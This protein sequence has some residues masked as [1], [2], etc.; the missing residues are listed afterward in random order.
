MFTLEE[1]RER[2]SDYCEGRMLFDEFEEWYRSN[3]WGHYDR[4]DDVLSG[5][6]AAV[7]AAFSDYEVDGITEEHFQRELVASVPA[8][9]LTAPGPTEVYSGF[10][11][12]SGNNSHQ[13]HRPSP[14]K[15][16]SNSSYGFS[17]A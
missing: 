15:A 3:S 2:V 5:A 7:E 14:Q 12:E 11:V 10:R 9:V 4:F 16:G 1:L 6:I 8:A 17:H 13:D